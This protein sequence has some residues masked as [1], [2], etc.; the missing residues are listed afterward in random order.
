MQYQIFVENPADQ[1]FMASAIGLPNATANGV[2]E[3]E[4]IGK[5]KSILDNRFKNGKLVIIEVD[6]PS[7]KSSDTS[8]PWIDNIG[9]FQDDPTFDDFLDEVNNYRKEI[10]MTGG[11]Q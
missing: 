8:D 11:H 5:L 4:A 3:K 2:T 7:E 1:I 10:E 6:L 9:I